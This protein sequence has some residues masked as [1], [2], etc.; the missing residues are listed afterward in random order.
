MR[1][2]GGQA[3][4][5]LTRDAGLDDVAV[6][7][8][9]DDVPDRLVLGPGRASLLPRSRVL[10]IMGEVQRRLFYRQSAVL[11]NGKAQADLVQGPRH[12]SDGPLFEIVTHAL[13]HEIEDNCCK[14]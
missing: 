8:S 1:N 2:R 9:N 12:H 7:F 5:V 4:E 6:C 11:R 10:P 14:L 13:L 3:Y